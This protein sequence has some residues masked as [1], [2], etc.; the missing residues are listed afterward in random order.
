MPYQRIRPI[1]RTRVMQYYS[2]YFGKLENVFFRES[3]NIIVTILVIIGVAQCFLQE[4]N[5]LWP[6]QEQKDAR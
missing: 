1:S 3:G 6:Q 2:N 4:T 5:D